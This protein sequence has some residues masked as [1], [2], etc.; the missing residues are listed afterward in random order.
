MS[1]IND[2][3]RLQSASTPELLTA[4]QRSTS[5]LASSFTSSQEFNVDE[6][7]FVKGIQIFRVYD[8]FGRNSGTPPVGG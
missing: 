4:H 6:T 1:V 5:E 8:F 3:D 2:H 7:P